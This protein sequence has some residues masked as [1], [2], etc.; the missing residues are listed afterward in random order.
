MIHSMTAFARRESQGDWGA[1]TIELRSVN[2][3]YLEL[4][5][6]LP[7]E[8][9]I[10]EPRIRDKM[11]QA[12]GRGKVDCT[13]RYQAPAEYTSLEINRELVT[14]LAHVTREIDGIIYNPAPVNSFD[15][16]RWPGVLQL[17]T[18][19][20]ERLHAEAM[21]LLDAALTELIATR[22]RE[23]DKLK[24]LLLQ[25]C[26]AMSEIVTQVNARRPEVLARARE[27]LDTKLAELKGEL[28]PSR[29]EQELVL[30]AQRLDVEEELDRLTAHLGEVRRV[31]E[32]KEPVGRR[33][34]FL[35]QELNREANTL[36]SKSQDVDTTRYAVDLK[37]L[38]EQMREQVQNIE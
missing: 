35:M 16:L 20:P 8:V 32:Q 34:D 28:D 26:T 21:G 33:L 25:R 12:L 27:R 5:L 3:R 29:L 36:S 23:G 4:G 18:P 19:D 24:D 6:R 1:F 13:I 30:L 10:L 22:A 15:V 7:E 17:P 38:I 14:Q 2:H 31:L 37:V 9:R 11:N